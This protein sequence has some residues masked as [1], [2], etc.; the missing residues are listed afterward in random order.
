MEV[1]RV[2]KFMGNTGRQLP[3]RRQPLGRHR[4]TAGLLEFFHHL[5]EADRDCLHLLVQTRQIGQALHLD[6]AHLAVQVARGIAE[7]DTDLRNRAVQPAS[8][9]QT[10]KHAHDR[11]RNQ[12]RQPNAGSLPC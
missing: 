2:A 4:L 8:D 5:P 3:N 1:K 10:A 9:P 12:E 7:R 6:R 11:S